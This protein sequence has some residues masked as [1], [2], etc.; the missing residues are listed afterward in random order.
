MSQERN[1]K[2]LSTPV[3]TTR[4]LAAFEAVLA[5]SG[6]PGALQ[7]LNARTAFRY[8]AIYRIDGGFMRNICLFDRLGQAQP[9][10]QRVPLGDSFCQFVLAGDRF[11]TND[12]AHDLRLDGHPFQGVLNAY[13]GLP[14]SRSPGTIY[15]TLCH[16]DLEPRQID[17]SEVPFLETIRPSLMARLP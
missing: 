13:F 11:Q 10:L 8:T 12:S 5:Q 16:F 15:G 6:L 7:F 1:A 4:D 9:S 2:L 17:D 14:L 3:E